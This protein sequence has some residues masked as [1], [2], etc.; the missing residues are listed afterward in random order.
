VT[1][2]L[3]LGLAGCWLPGRKV[4]TEGGW[5]QHRVPTIFRSGFA[6]F[7]WRTGVTCPRRLAGAGS[8]K[9]ATYGPRIPH[10]C[11]SS[12]GRRDG[13][14]RWTAEVRFSGALRMGVDGSRWESMGVD[15]SRWESMGLRRSAVGAQHAMLIGWARV[16]GLT[17][18]PEIDPGKTKG[19]GDSPVATMPAEISQ[20]ATK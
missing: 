17:L 1:T 15:G 4:E 10:R 2:G 19:H 12:N 8:G 18:T 13:E 9:L 16:I 20:P 11:S 7:A 14:R 6:P 5:W 3:V